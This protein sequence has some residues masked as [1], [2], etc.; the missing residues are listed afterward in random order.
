MAP[1]KQIKKTSVVGEIKGQENMSL[2]DLF[3]KILDTSAIDKEIETACVKYIKNFDKDT[4]KYFHKKMMEVADINGKFQTHYFD[5][6][7]FLTFINSKKSADEQIVFNNNLVI[8]HKVI[9]VVP[10]LTQYVESK[11][12]ENIQEKIEI[13]ENQ[14][15]IVI[16][17]EFIEDDRIKSDNGFGLSEDEIKTVHVELEDEIKKE[18]ILEIEDEDYSRKTS[19][20]VVPQ[21]EIKEEVT[22]EA[23]TETQKELEIE[24]V[25]NSLDIPDN[26]KN[27]ELVS[28]SENKSEDYLD[29]IEKNKKEERIKASSALLDDEEEKEESN[30]NNILDALRE[31]YK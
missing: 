30:K 6:E 2:F 18:T 9:N 26:V 31:E 28:E 17:E 29:I 24:E 25:D 10:Q 4:I 15:K 3:S 14:E 27:E 16:E 1:K 11:T 5:F 12:K 7:T 21:I 13:E 8:E 22:F 20:E 23:K 19:V